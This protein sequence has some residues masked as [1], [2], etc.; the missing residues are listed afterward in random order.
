MRKGFHE[1]VEK[2]RRFYKT[3]EVAEAEGGFAVLLD[4]RAL[5]TP[6]GVRLLLPT[7]ANAEQVAAEW[8]AQGDTLELAQMH[9]TRLANTA[10]DSIGKA[11]EAT[12][13]QIARYAGSDLLLY[14]A[15]DPEALVRRQTEH[16]GPLL[17][18]AEAEARLSFVRASGIIHQ[19]QP[20]ETLAEVRRIA[21]AL[22]DFALAGLAFGVALFGSAILA[23]GVQRGW[24]NGVQAF[25]LSRLDEAWQEEQWGVDEEAAERTAKL[26]GEAEML[27]RWFRGLTA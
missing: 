17:D 5:R 3:V 6:G 4:G 11:R 22:D 20:Q 26:R 10:I 8:E 18:R 1:P 19:E 27:G 23:I 16:W 24:L 25:E 9:A 2:P 13:D 12:A 7:R 15:E 14:F 21:L